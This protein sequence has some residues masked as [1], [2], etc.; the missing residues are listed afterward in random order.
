MSD[1]VQLLAEARREA[2]RRDDDAA[3]EGRDV[4]FGVSALE[5]W[6]GGK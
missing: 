1:P 4:R 3:A 6:N 2:A 5:R